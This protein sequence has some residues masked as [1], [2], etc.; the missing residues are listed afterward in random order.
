MTPCTYPEPVAGNGDNVHWVHLAA[1]R[2]QDFGDLVFEY[3]KGVPAVTKKVCV[4]ARVGLTKSFSKLITLS[5][6]AK[7]R[8]RSSRKIPFPFL[9]FFLVNA[10]LSFTGWRF[11]NGSPPS[12]SLIKSPA[13]SSTSWST[14]AS[15]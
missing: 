6:L 11:F 4:H 7:M 10:R 12:R 8:M 2:E 14:M 5:C 3:C 13:N 15:V 9:R 1:K